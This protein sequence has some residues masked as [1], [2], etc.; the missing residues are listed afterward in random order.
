MP[1]EALAAE[2]TRHRC[3]LPLEMRNRQ[4]FVVDALSGHIIAPWPPKRPAHG[5]EYRLWLTA[6]R[7]GDLDALPDTL[8]WCWPD[9]EPVPVGNVGAGWLKNY[10]RDR[11]VYALP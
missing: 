5:D 3:P 9:R 7:L 10:E 8:C 2:R 1:R 4:P 11:A 6:Q